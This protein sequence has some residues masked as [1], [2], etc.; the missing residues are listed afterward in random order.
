M[1]A[2]HL[3]ALSARHRTRH[4]YFS[5]DSVAPKTLVKLAER[6]A[7]A[8][9]D[10]AWGTD[11]K[12]EKYLTAERAEVLRRAGAVACAL[13]VESAAP[14]VLE[15]ID[16]GAPIEVV[17]DVVDRLAAAGIAPEAMCF[18]EFPTETRDEALATVRWIEARR[19]RLGLFILGEFGLT[20]GALVAQ[21]PAEFGLAETWQVEGDEL[22]LGLFF[23]ETRPAKTARD[24]AAIDRALDR[25]GGRFRLRSYPWAGAVST[26]HTLLYY[27]RLGRTAFHREAP[28]PTPWSDAAREA[29]LAYDVDALAAAEARDAE[30]WS[31][32]I[33]DRRAVS[34]AAYDELAAAQPRATP[35][36]ARY[37]FAAGADPARL[38]GRRRSAAPNRL[39]D[40]S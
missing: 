26:A 21:R 17:G 16:K 1:I 28:A 20:H 5:Q 18:T 8:G 3:G 38:T 2:E 33:H 36:P 4:F 39:R 24:R 6:I 19:D 27:A 9:L 29:P 22:G 40:R 34:R 11:L 13:G 25:V 35:R 10:L 7:A 37:R 30:I 32:L 31:T 14:R 15:L 23:A 12:P